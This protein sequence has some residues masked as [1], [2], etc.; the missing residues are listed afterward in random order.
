MEI[1][2]LLNRVY[3]GNTV[4]DYLWVVGSLLVGFIFLR[5]IAHRIS[6]VIFKLVSKDATK[7]DKEA[8]HDLVGA[9]IRWLIML[10][11][12]FVCTLHL[13]YPE[14]WEMAPRD[15]FGVR[16]VIYRIYIFSLITIIT[17]IALRFVKFLGVVLME[18][19]E[20][21]ESKADDQIIPF[22]IEILK[23]LVI[24]LAIFIVMGTVF[25]IDIAALVA[26]LGIGGLAL[27]LAAKESLE[28]L[29]ASFMI[30]FDKPFMIGD[31]VTVNGV[32]GTVEKI[33]FRSTRIRTLEKSYLTIPNLQ[34]VNN[35]LDNLS[36]RTF[37]RVSFNV[38][39]TYSSTQEQIKNIVRDIQKYIDEHP[40]T[41]QEG[42]IHFM[43]FGS[44]SLDIMVLYF[45]D[46]MDW[47]TFLNIKE[48]INFEIM[49]IVEAHGAGF[50]F[51]TQTIHL[52]K[53]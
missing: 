20:L 28:N 17:W 38:G 42:E 37:R 34:M 26:G 33:G 13:E 53:S 43:E 24:V 7:L 52:E 45:I 11:T 2:Q 14:S 36:M 32:T 9:P 27:A 12:V 5:F 51:P 48:E 47:R 21:T 50:A 25:K 44:S 18:R 15:E 31:L 22:L 41:N 23:I 3:L 40:H 30:F 8:L 49:R 39:V 46:T 6:D 29:L 16:M 35:V 19:A 1:N 10:I 4:Q